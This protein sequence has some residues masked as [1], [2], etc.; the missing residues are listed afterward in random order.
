MFPACIRF[1][2]ESQLCEHCKTATNLQ[3]LS[4]CH[5]APD[6]CHSC[7]GVRSLFALNQNFRSER[8]GELPRHRRDFQFTKRNCRLLSDSF[9]LRVSHSLL[10][11]ARSIVKWDWRLTYAAIRP[12]LSLQLARPF[13]SDAIE[14]T[15]SFYTFTAVV[16]HTFLIVCPAQTPTNRLGGSNGPKISNCFRVLIPV[17]CV[18]CL[19]GAVTV[20]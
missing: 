11:P 6:K 8:D 14:F 10:W 1:R 7:I 3:V 13:N 9:L 4:G 16:I 17:V 18:Y 2:E 20:W 15:A 19:H 5:P 12:M